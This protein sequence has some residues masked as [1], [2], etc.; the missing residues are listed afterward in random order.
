MEKFYHTKNIVNNEKH[1][2]AYCGKELFPYVEMDHYEE[3]TYYHCDC[4]DA[5]YEHEL[6]IK[7]N[8]LKDEMENICR[9]FPKPKYKL[10][11]IEKITKIT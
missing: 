11:Y 1:Y 8:A 9:Q 5:N 3:Y 2:C 10:E 7:L 4:Q 6:Q